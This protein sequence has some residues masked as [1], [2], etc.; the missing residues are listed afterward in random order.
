MSYTT[1][2]WI[3]L[4]GCLLFLFAAFNPSAMVFGVQGAQAKLEVIRR[5]ERLW[6][7]SQYAFGLGAV[8]AAA[9]YLLLARAG[10]PLAAHGGLLMLVSSGMLA[11]ALLWGIN[12]YMRATDFEGF[13]NGTQPNWPFLAYTLLTLLG[14]AVWGYVYLQGGFPVWLGWGTMAP[15][16]ILLGLLLVFRDM[17]PFV[18]YLI[19]LETVW[20]LF[21][22]PPS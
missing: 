14:L 4:I 17:P 5:H 7:I 18:Y 19:G 10:G 1:I 16:L 21:K 8:V 11:G 20:V 3:I 13:A 6:V 15:A 12:L 2:A 22:Q 9:G